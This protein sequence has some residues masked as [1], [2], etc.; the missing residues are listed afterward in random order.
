MLGH[1]PPRKRSNLPAQHPLVV[2]GLQ[3]AHIDLSALTQ[4]PMQ[5]GSFVALSQ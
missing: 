2:E 1:H 3:Q 5:H 4:S